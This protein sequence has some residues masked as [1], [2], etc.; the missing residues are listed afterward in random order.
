MDRTISFDAVKASAVA[1]LYCF[2]H[3]CDLQIRRGAGAAMLGLE[4]NCDMQDWPSYLDFDLAAVDAVK[5]LETVYRYGVHAE[6]QR[7]GINDDLE[8]GN[9]GRLQALLP[10]VYD[11]HIIERNWD[12]ISD[13]HGSH[14]RG[15]ALSTV[16]ELATAR[17]HLD[18]ERFV[19]LS[20]VALL[21]NMLER[22][23]RNALHA[24][25][26]SM[27]VAV[28]DDHGELVVE[29]MEALRW[30]RGRRGFKETV[31]LDTW[32]SPVPT[33]LRPEEVMPF[34][35]AR[36]MDF[37]SQEHLRELLGYTDA[38]I[39]HARYDNVASW[40]GL[41]VEKVER[42]FRGNLEDLSPDDCPVLS[43]ILMLDTAWLSAQVL[44]A[45]FPQAM[46]EIMPVRAETAPVAISPFNEREAS[47]DVKLTDAGVR[48]GY[49]DIE[50]RY[51]ER[52]FPAD[53]FG[54]RGGD[55]HGIAVEL[56]HDLT[57]K[58]PYVTD[59]RVKSEALVTPRK[60]FSAYFTAHAAK[61][62]DV[63]RIRRTDER[64]YEL[65]FIAQ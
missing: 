63:I 52:L 36:L 49:F 31:Q 22:S 64:A 14:D 8:D 39:E 45:K 15:E 12:D 38:Q 21:S 65:T 60:R 13:A 40:R 42:L 11:N 18:Y 17:F 59:L 27:L 19:P 33:D 48:N 23:V 50:A 51:A 29:K 55:Q 57:K 26:E 46:R 53:C 41:P 6:L 7:P 10:L 34:L 9:L 47:L 43:Q 16:I 54:S 61:A 58:S 35:R 5:D 2:A 4:P 62:G 25:G 28:R 30:L 20:D 32:G 56:H 3:T 1:T 37:S 24:E 44:R